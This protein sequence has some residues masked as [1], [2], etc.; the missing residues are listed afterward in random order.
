MEVWGTGKPVREFIYV[1]DC[2]DAIVLAAELYDDAAKPLNIGTGIGTTIRELAETVCA[3]S[4][5]AGKMVWN[6]DKPD[7]AMLKVLDV[8]RM[9]AA[10]DGWRPATDLRTGLTKTIT[11]YRANKAQADAKW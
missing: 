3:A 4:G 5:Y 1:E 11:W 9:S 10:L 6:T 7:G 2:A 8:T